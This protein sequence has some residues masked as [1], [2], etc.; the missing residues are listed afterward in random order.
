MLNLAN[1]MSS[2][3]LHPNCQIRA[4]EL[5]SQMTSLV[6]SE[7][8]DLALIMNPDSILKYMVICALGPSLDPIKNGLTMLSI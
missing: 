6:S 1:L 4:M 7:E 3:F 5:E 8:L 2:Q